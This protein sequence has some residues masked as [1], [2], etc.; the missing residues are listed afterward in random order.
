M[1]N[2]RLYEDICE[3]L[4]KELHEYYYS[5]KNEKMT[6]E[7]LDILDKILH[8]VKSVS[9]IKA[10]ND[11]YDERSSYDSYSNRS[12]RRSYDGYGYGYDNR[13]GRDGDSD[14][15][16]SE[17]SYG[18]SGHSEKDVMMNKLQKMMDESNDQHEREIIQ[19]YMH[20]L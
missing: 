14:G 16:Y 17:N 13:R 2:K 6:P 19:N 20:K 4:D 7:E 5:I 12:M 11:A 15:R 3:R 8:A 9:T 1:A 18:Y 10:M